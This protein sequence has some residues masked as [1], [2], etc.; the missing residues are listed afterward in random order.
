M[1]N[2]RVWSEAGFRGESWRVHQTKPKSDVKAR[3]TNKLARSFTTLDLLEQ[4]P[5]VFAS[6]CF[7]D[8]NAAAFFTHDFGATG[9][10]YGLAENQICAA[11]YTTAL[12]EKPSL[13]RSNDVFKH[14]GDFNCF[15][16]LSQ[17]NLAK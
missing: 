8:K 12:G 4:G 7:F 6:F 10:L 14:Q 2:G 17:A 16:V 9:V 11:A 15:T 13:D 5:T 3:R 1:I